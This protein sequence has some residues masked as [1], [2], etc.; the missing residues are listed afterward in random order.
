MIDLMLVYGF[1]MIVLWGEQLVQF[2]NDGYVEILVDKYFGGLGQLMCEC[3]F[4]VWYINGLIYQC[5][6]QGEIII[7]E[8]K[9]Y[10][11]V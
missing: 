2:Y 1:L 5:V 11:L 10:L 7:Y 3:W 6:W 4:E 8:D 9:F